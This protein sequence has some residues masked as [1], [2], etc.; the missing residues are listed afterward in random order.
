MQT[1][2]VVRSDAFDEGGRIPQKYTCD[3]ADVSPPLSWSGAP[4]ETQA[5][6]LLVTDPDA[7]NFVHWAVVDI[8]AVVTTLDE[9]SSGADAGGTEAVNSFGQ[10][11]WGGPCPPSGEHRYVY[12]VYALDSRIGL[13]ERPDAATVRNALEDH[14]LAHGQLTASYARA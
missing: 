6:A 4:D 11:G 3:G 5:Y 12:T 2:L 8:P 10:V 13:E 1:G 9:G 7:Q 14:V